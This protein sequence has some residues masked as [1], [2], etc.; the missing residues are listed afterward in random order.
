MLMKQQAQ[1]GNR[2]AE[3]PPTSLSNGVCE[4]NSRESPGPHRG[5]LPQPD[6]M[7]GPGQ[8]QQQQPPQ[9]QQQQPQ[10]EATG[11]DA[12]IPPLLGVAPLGKWALSKECYYQLQQLTWASQ[13]LP[14]PSDSD[15]LRSYLIRQPCVTPAYYPL[16]VPHADPQEIF[17][18]LTT[19]TLFFIFYY[20]EGTKV[21]EIIESGH[22]GRFPTRPKLRT[23]R[24][25]LSSNSTAFAFVLYLFFFFSMSLRRSIWR[26]RR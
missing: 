19:D 8:P 26:R 2:T 23:S 17:Q 3:M 20:M 5:Q 21:V 1:Q 22:R 25:R 15:R 9:Q 10:Q 7:V 4:P 6:Q 12:H 11:G 24:H 14:H 13:H 18:R 16:S